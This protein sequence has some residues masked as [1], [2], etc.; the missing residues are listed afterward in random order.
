VWAWPRP[1]WGQAA[2]PQTGTGIAARREC[3]A[4]S[5]LCPSLCCVRPLLCVRVTA[6]GA[7]QC[8]T[9][10]RGRWTARRRG[11][12]VQRTGTASEPQLYPTSITPVCCSSMASPHTCAC[13]AC[14][15]C[16][17]R[18][19]AAPPAKRLAASHPRPSTAR[20][21]HWR[22]DGGHR[23]LLGGGRANRAHC[24][25]FPSPSLPAPCKHAPA[26]SLWWAHAS[27]PCRPVLSCVR[28]GSPAAAAAACG[29]FFLAAGTEFARRRGQTTHTNTRTIGVPTMHDRSQPSQSTAE[30]SVGGDR[31]L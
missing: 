21:G 26:V 23:T 18:V 20:D 14:C 29:C 16:S 28:R 17:L 31:P 27:V 11:T 25:S 7:Q 5:A 10:W 13:V 2:R 19:G 1:S 12:S 9:G 30:T 3:T 15:V 4:D 24:T 22:R 8:A 6:H